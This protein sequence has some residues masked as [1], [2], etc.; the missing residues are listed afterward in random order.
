MPRRPS[1]GS[2]DSVST[3][4]EPHRPADIYTPNPFPLDPTQPGGKSVHNPFFPQTKTTTTESPSSHRDPSDKVNSSQTPPNKT[5]EKDTSGKV[6]SQFQRFGASLKGVFGKGSS[7]LVSPTP[8]LPQKDISVHD[9]DDITERRRQLYA[10]TSP[11]SP[12]GSNS[13]TSKNSRRDSYHGLESPT[14]SRFPASAS[15]PAPSA[16]SRGSNRG[17]FANEMDEQMDPFLPSG[18]P[19]SKLPTSGGPLSYPLDRQPSPNS[20]SRQQQPGYPGH[21]PTL[22]STNS[23]P[24][25]VSA[26]PPNHRRSH[27]DGTLSD[28]DDSVISSAST[29]RVSRPHKQ[30]PSHPPS[31]SSKRWS[32]PVTSSGVYRPSPLAHQSNFDDEDM[33]YPVD[34]GVDKAPVR[35]PPGQEGEGEQKDLDGQ[36]S[37]RQEQQRQSIERPSSR[38]YHLGDA[39]P[40]QPP[41]STYVNTGR[42]YDPQD[43][44][45]TSG[46]ASHLNYVGGGSE[47]GMM[48]YWSDV[49]IRS[50]RY[51]IPP[52][53]YARRPLGGEGPESDYPVGYYGRE[54]GYGD[55]LYADYDQYGDSRYV[56]PAG[57]G[58]DSYEMEAVDTMPDAQSV[59]GSEKKS[60]S[61]GGIQLAAD[62]T[63]KVSETEEA[64]SF[65]ETNSQDGEAAGEGDGLTTGELK[66]P[67]RPPNKRRLILRIIGL[68][69]SL[70]TIGFV[71]AAYPVS[72]KSTPFSSVYGVVIHFLV[73]II[74]TIISIAFVFNYFSRRLHR[75][76]KMKR[77]VLLGLDI[78]LTLFWFADVFI[79]ISRFPCAIG[80]NDGWCD[81]YNTSIFTAVL[82]MISFLVAFGWDIWGAFERPKKYDPRT[83]PALAEGYFD[84][85][86]GQWLPGGYPMDPAT[87]AEYGYVYGYG[88][89]PDGYGGRGGRGG[90][91]YTARGR[92]R[93][94]HGGRG[95]GKKNKLPFEFR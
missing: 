7:E 33:R 87:A 39:E 24:S 56:N 51:Y 19:R 13:N 86:T 36:E 89:E 23:A 22:F 82:A 44:M 26:L 18:L 71:S 38:I 11:T 12:T 70:A 34:G 91:R 84:P 79:C 88:Y 48:G 29:S 62:R 35:F 45:F 50:D 4:P 6:K 68:F 9:G 54:N 69:A 40:L 14:G 20:A 78:I 66:E 90:G 65:A 49:P 31:A 61:T 16:S 57:R 53:R 64:T 37:R 63:K 28:T 95:R 30:R 52:H 32:T 58:R 41:R 43:R 92:G 74:S 15:P 27:Q 17:Y 46:S 93:G 83:D 55:D 72:G 5:L 80:A 73:A 3:A 2:A 77:Y 21:D 59:V 94:G 75:K 47:G 8:P 81:M 76:P 1:S 10:P 85:T 60:S 67:A 42:G 25:L